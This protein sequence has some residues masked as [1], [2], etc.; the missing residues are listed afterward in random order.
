MLSSEGERIGYSK[1]IY[2]ASV[3]G[4]T[5]NG[6]EF[7]AVMPKLLRAWQ[8]WRAKQLA[9]E[10][11]RLDEVGGRMETRDELGDTDQSK[12]ETDPRGEPKDPWTYVLKLPLVDETGAKYIYTT[13]SYGGKKAILGL[14]GEY[15]VKRPLL[16]VVSLQSGTYKHAE[17]GLPHFPILKVI[18]WADP[19]TF[20]PVSPGKPRLPAAKPD[21]DDSLDDLGM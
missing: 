7:T 19:E 6:A 8:N 13:G 11:V 5:L 20:A 21:L 3:S 12:W 17:Y 2:L 14:G 18:G 10:R 16:P 15:Y 9:D 1:G 4:K